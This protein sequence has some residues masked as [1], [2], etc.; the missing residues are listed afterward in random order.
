MDKDFAKPILLR[1]LNFLS[2]PLPRS[3]ARLSR[4]ASELIAN[5]LVRAPNELPV[6][7]VQPMSRHLCLHNQLSRLPLAIYLNGDNL[8]GTIPVSI[9]ELHVLDLSHNNFTGSIPETV[10]HLINLEK[11][12]FSDNSFFGEIPS[13]LE[14]LHFLSSFSVANNDLQLNTPWRS[15]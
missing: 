2:G 12:S 14:K 10:S 4:L 6:L 1:F 9:G 5:R 3:V 7:L 13:S 8:T 11:L 15:A